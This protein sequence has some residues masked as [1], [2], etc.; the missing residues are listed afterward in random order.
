MDGGHMT[1]REAPATRA[2]FIGLGSQGGPMARRI[3]EA[4]LPLTLW[5]RRP[6]SV[7]PYADTAAVVAASPAALGAA[8]DVVGVCVV[9]DADVEAVLLGPDG[10]L[11][12]M[13]PGGVVA[14]HSTI[15]PDTCRRLA[16][17]AAER[18]V[19]LVD[20]PVSGGARPRPRAR[21]W[22]WPG[23]TPTRS[24]GAGRCSTRSRARWPTSARSAAARW[25]S[26][27]TTWPSPRR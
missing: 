18:G 21:S 4:G 3:A 17:R 1:E 13:A 2:G 6:E 27:S 26:C 24:T 14:V 8:S 11:A 20:A 19:A 7:A 23:A 22:S 15:R 9:A 25:R 10:V 5:A 16:E 12:G